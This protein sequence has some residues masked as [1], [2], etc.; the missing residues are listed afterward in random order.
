MPPPVVTVITATYN[1]STA[2]R[3]TIQSAL[4]QT[5]DDFEL[6]VVG[7]ACT[8]DSEAVVSSFDDSR[9]HWVNLPQR[10]GS[11]YGPNN[12]GLERARGEYIAYLGHDDLWW[13][14]HLE[15]GLSTLKT[16][17]ADM[18]V[19]VAV[20]NGPSTSG[21]KGV[22]GL[23]PND[24][25]TPRYDFSP[26][27]MIHTRSL[28]E[29]A[30]PWRSPRESEIGVDH[31]FVTRCYKAGGK[32]VPTKELTVF[33]F[34]TS[35]RRNAYRTRNVD[36]HAALYA[37]MQAGGE[38]FRRAELTT[39]LQRFLEDRFFRVEGVWDE[40]ERAKVDSVRRAKQFLRFKGADDVAA[41]PPLGAEPV[42][43]SLGDDYRG[44]EWHEPEHDPVHGHYRWSGPSTE[45]ALPLPVAVNGPCRVTLH[46]LFVLEPETLAALSVLVDGRPVAT[47]LERT[48]SDTWLLAFSVEPARHGDVEVTLV[49]P[50]TIRPFDISPSMDRRWL[51]LAV[52]WV[53]ISELKI[54]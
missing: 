44:F 15:T 38:D 40:A 20:I 1:L 23:F 19:A 51:G 45:S 39:A 27:T 49:V 7:D 32:I 16:T 30:G 21:F 14:G 53:E 13:P 6:F 43:C 42:R 31:D 36:E 28:V 18:A 17:G 24:V 11:Q 2:L 10:C 52:N 54:R 47:A 12:A 3:C 5:F 8:D 41:L 29:R 35:F 25:Y 34:N 37:R 46:I 4:A 26:S 48:D 50:R 22:T 33:K 9:V